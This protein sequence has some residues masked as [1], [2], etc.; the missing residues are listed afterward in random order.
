MENEEKK[1]TKL[2]QWNQPVPVD[3]ETQQFA[4]KN[5]SESSGSE[6]EEKSFSFF[7]GMDWG[8]SLKE[9]AIAENQYAEIAKQNEQQIKE[10]EASMGE[11]AKAI[12]QVYGDVYDLD[13]SLLGKASPEQLDELMEAISTKIE[14]E[15]EKEAL[16]NKKE[17]LIKKIIEVNKHSSKLQYIWKS[18]PYITIDQ[19]PQYKDKIQAKIDWYKEQLA[20]E[21]P[22]YVTTSYPDKIKALEE[23]ESKYNELMEAKK[24]QDELEE[25]SPKFGL[26]EG[27]NAIIAKFQ[28][29]KSMYSQVR[30]NKAIWCQSVSES[31]KAFSVE[32]KNQRENM[33][34]EEINSLR[35]YTGAG[36]STINFP[37]NGIKYSSGW[38]STGKQ[39]AFKQAKLM[40]EALDKSVSS[41]DVWLQRGV[42]EMHFGGIDFSDIV[43][44]KVE[45]SSL[46]GKEFINNSF[47]SCGSAKGTGFSNSSVTLNIYCPKGTKMHYVNDISHYSGG[48][49]E[50]IINR[51]YHFVI[52]KV[53]KAKN[54]NYYIDVDLIVGSDADR[55]T[56]EQMKKI[57]DKNL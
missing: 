1:D 13:A 18:A 57:Y 23:W 32:A 33:S 16:E 28:D 34:S 26:L 6:E 50:T 38:G 53:E 51:G 10:A 45:L 52:K 9:N 21:N 12:H 43:K 31:K 41:Q 54:G 30:K 22:Q 47:M 46:V 39:K 3:P 48:E 7:S 29:S 14:V 25:S 35:D 36:A 2:N 40:T 44:G 17:E 55:L 27:S 56:D 8:L 37:L 4:P 5:G 19:Y 11:K 49:N 42:S 15:S 20:S 24:Q